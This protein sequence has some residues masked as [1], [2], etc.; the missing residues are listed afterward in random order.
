[1]A[2]EVCFRH[3][4]PA[5][6]S[7]HSFNVLAALLYARSGLCIASDK[8]YLLR[9]RL[10]PLARK[11][12]F[13]DI[14][15]LVMRLQAPGTEALTTSVVEAMT[16]NETMFFRNEAPFVHLARTTLP[17]LARVRPPE[18]TLRIWSA[19]ASTGQEAYSIA[20]TV[21]D[22]G[23][24]S[25]KRRVEI[26]GTDIAAEPLARARSGL[27]SDLEV[28]RG[29]P[30]ALRA[31]H[32]VRDGSMWRISP[33]LRQAVMFRVFNLLDDARALGRFDIIFCRNVLIYFDAATKTRVL[34]SLR[35]VLAPDGALYLG[36]AET[37]IGL[38]TDF[39]PL[40]DEAGVYIC[41]SCPTSSFVIA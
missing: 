18:Q 23:L 26:L 9:A 33:A 24:Q 1:M 39:V 20:M 40:A 28:Q 21:A 25:E 2:T 14:D 32:F 41:A 34:A 38:Q 4:P 10:E 12:G 31:R 19:A 36:G 30:P 35:R 15:A 8:M 17:Y 13:R 7:P 11:S 27:Y 29:L 6:M 16:I 22:S 37:V 3:V 5:R